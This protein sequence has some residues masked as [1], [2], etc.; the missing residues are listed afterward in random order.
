MNK[1]DQQILRATLIL[2]FFVLSEPIM[3]KIFE[4]FNGYLTYLIREL[5]KFF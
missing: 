5:D 2:L 4:I 3:M 1:R